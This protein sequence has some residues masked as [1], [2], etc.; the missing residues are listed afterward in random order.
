MTSLILSLSIIVALSLLVAGLRA[1]RAQGKREFSRQA[2]RSMLIL[3]I[4]GLG[5]LVV[6]SLSLVSRAFAQGTQ[7]PS[8][9]ALS[10]DAGMGFLGAGTATGLAAIGAGIA[11]GMTGS[12]AIGAMA[13]K[14]ELFG[15]SLVIVGLAEGIA[16]YGL[17]IAILIL[18]R[19]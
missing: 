7:A 10:T 13:E 16:I 18:A 11:V 6:L 8:L 17:I 1:V 15:R 12:A 3:N 14:P 2:A 19:I 5:L 9:Q 4:L